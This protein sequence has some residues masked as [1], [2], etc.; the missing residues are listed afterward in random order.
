MELNEQKII[1]LCIAKIKKGTQKSGEKEESPLK[2]SFTAKEIKEF[3]NL[4]SNSRGIY[5]ELKAIANK[6]TSRKI[7]IQ[8]GED[9]CFIVPIPFCE[10]KKSIFTIRFDRVMEEYL[11]ELKD[12]FTKYN[13]DN[14]RRLKSNYSIRLYEL[15][16][17][18]EW[19]REKEFELDKL[20][21]MLGIKEFDDRT[22][23]WVDIYPKYANIKQRV[24]IPVQKELLEKTDIYFEFE[25][26]KTGRKVTSLKFK[27]LKNSSA[28]ESEEDEE[29]QLQELSQDN[30]DNQDN[31]EQEVEVN[32]VL[33]EKVKERTLEGES[34]KSDL[35]K[36]INKVQ[37][38]QKVNQKESN[39]DDLEQQKVQQQEDFESN[40]IEDLDDLVD[41]VRLFIKEPLKTKEIKIL[42]SVAN[43][44]I[45][46]IKEKY[47]IAKQQLHIN[48][49]MAWLISAIKNDYAKPVETESN[50]P[51]IATQKVNRF[52]NYEQDD[53][54]FDKLEKLER[55]RIKRKLEK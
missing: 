35:E 1:L 40:S 21:K 44:D 47:N 38:Q 27:I 17:A 46:L 31:I 33:E 20:K 37:L 7:Y 30:Q 19:L 15:L 26:I 34:Q 36:L 29:E 32:E 43:N 13:I 24:L 55:E 16:K 22:N 11:L 50:K 3:L 48:N 2:F 8:N 51:M 6:L 39:K 18:F 25:E 12:R 49:L 28:N 52:V 41:A 23:K 5:S 53:W 54:D 4:D 10:Y 14:I 42:L 9:F 45:S